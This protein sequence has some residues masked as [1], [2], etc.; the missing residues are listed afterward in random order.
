MRQAS[1]KRVRMYQI[2]ATYQEIQTTGYSRPQYKYPPR[3]TDQ[4][5]QRDKLHLERKDLLYRAAEHASHR[6]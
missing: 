3:V 6:R 2:P 5:Y 1:S 4:D